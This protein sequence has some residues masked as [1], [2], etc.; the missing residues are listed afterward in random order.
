MEVSEKELN[1]IRE[2][3]IKFYEL[4]KYDGDIEKKVNDI[5]D[6]CLYGWY[7]SP[8]SFEDRIR[9]KIGRNS[10]LFR[11]NI[12]ENRIS[13]D[14]DGSDSKS[15]TS[16][17]TDQ[18]NSKLTFTERKF[19]QD[20]EKE[21]RQDYE[22]NNSSDLILLNEILVDEL[23]LNRLQ[24]ERILSNDHS[25]L[26]TRIEKV[27]KRITDK[28]DKLGILRSQRADRDFGA[29]GNI[30]QLSTLVEEKIN[31]ISKLKDAR[32]RKKKMNDLKNKFGG[33]DEEQFE[34]LYKEIVLQYKHDI[35][36]PINEISEA[37]MEKLL[38][39]LGSSN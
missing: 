34:M 14:Y 28:M 30:S 19:L 32:E 23:V 25:R 26:E 35:E 17:I 3:L 29:D 31:Q 2:D 12:D 6:Q 24:K 18:I 37:E 36:P 9:A 27:Q 11:N 15:K 1:E 10:V 13:P 16:Y 20:R 33:I 7:R 22:F 39:D 8:K 4:N 38:K 21:Y 5:I